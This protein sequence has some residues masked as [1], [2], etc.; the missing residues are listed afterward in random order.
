MGR[1]HAREGKRCGSPSTGAVQ[2]VR[3]SCAIAIVVF[4]VGAILAKP[5]AAASSLG[6]FHAF[7]CAG[8]VAAAHQDPYATTPLAACE[9]PLGLR[10][11][12]PGVPARVL[13][14][15]LPAYAIGFFELV[16]LLPFGTAAMLWATLLVASASLAIFLFVRAAGLPGDVLLAALS[17]A[18]FCVSVASGELVP[19]ALLGMALATWGTARDRP[20]AIAAGLFLAM[21]EPQVGVV[22]GLALAVL[23]PRNAFIVGATFALLAVISLLVLGFDQNVRYLAVVLPQHILSELSAGQQYSVSWIATRAGSSDE[24]AVGLGRASYILTAI[25]AVG[26]AWWMRKRNSGVFAVLAAPALAVC[27]GPFLHLDHIALAIPAA[28][29]FAATGDRALQN[30]AIAASISLA[31]PLAYV[32]AHPAL[33][34]VLPLIAGSI[35]F[36]LTGHAIAAIRVA[37]GGAVYAML[38]ALV[39]A[40]VTMHTVGAGAAAAAGDL[41]STPWGEYLRAQTPTSWLVWAVKLNTWFG[42]AATAVC[43]VRER[44]VTAE[45][46]AFRSVRA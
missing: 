8:K 29:A 36:G 2:G 9:V 41:A 25:V 15:P 11:L 34:V 40:H 33:F 10:S 37:A 46:S 6:D 18:L 13:P 42:L 20:S 21:A 14:A 22:L 38:F 39:A 19:I 44:A 17:I 45:A 27:G 26:V 12:F 28:V 4:C 24:V 16:A 1:L 23:R 3:W 31:L 7:F 32:F 30:L 35:C 43:A 5:N